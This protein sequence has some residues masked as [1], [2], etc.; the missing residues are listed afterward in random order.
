MYEL[1]SDCTDYEIAVSKVQQSYEKPKNE[2]HARYTT[3]WEKPEEILD[4]YL[5]LRHLSE[6]CNYK[7]VSAE[8]HK[9]EA[10]RDDLKWIAVH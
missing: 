4:K 9:A 10:I 1:I 6:D 7:A 2:I 5:K 8:E 3:H